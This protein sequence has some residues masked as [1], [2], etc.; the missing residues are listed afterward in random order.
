VSGAHLVVAV[1]GRDNAAPVGPV[2]QKS[3][4]NQL[5]QA[6]EALVA[7]YASADL[8]LTLVTID[9]ALGADHL[10]TWATSPSWW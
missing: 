7:A 5:G 4:E 10:T 8:L 1:P 2:P 3:S 9:P 6:S